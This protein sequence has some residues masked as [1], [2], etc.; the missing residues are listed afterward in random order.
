LV[1]TTN[2]FIPGVL[3]QVWALGGQFESARLTVIPEGET[4]EVQKDTGVIKF[5]TDWHFNLN[6][7][8]KL[9]VEPSIGSEVIYL[10]SIADQSR[11]RTYDKVEGGRHCVQD[12]LDFLPKVDDLL[13]I[14]GNT[15][16]INRVLANHRVETGEY[17]L[18]VST[19]GPA[20]LASR[21]ATAL[22][23]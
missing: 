8:N 9:T 3:E 15:P 22:V 20:I 16:T 17:L 23:V 19:P 13:W 2:R 7:D 6:K 5:R 21:Q 18:G 12:I 10:R 4:L 14:V 11:R 1:A